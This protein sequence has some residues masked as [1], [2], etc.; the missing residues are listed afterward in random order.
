MKNPI[1]QEKFLEIL[2]SLY[3]TALSGAESKNFDSAEILARKYTQKTKDKH[4]AAK[5][6]ARNELMKTS[7]SGF[8]ASLGGLITIPL[9][10]PA[11]M[12]VTFLVQIRMI[13]AIAY[14]G[15]VNLHD[16]ELKTVVFAL[17]LGTEVEDTFIKVGLKPV[18]KKVTYN[19]LKKVP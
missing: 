18:G 13:L 14:A 10:V 6:I 19:L 16:A 12:Y 1:T 17:L 9:T 11:D 2:D 3:A 7:S 15:G 5:K 8:L 4:E